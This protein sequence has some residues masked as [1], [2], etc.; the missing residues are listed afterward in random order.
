MSHFSLFHSLFF[1][2]FFCLFVCFIYIKLICD[3]LF[4]FNFFFVFSKLLYI[5]VQNAIYA[6]IVFCFL[7][8]SIFKTINSMLMLPFN[9]Y[10]FLD[11]Y[12]LHSFFRLLPFFFF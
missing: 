4:Y 7:S 5:I 12:I 9:V 1:T 10:V 11:Y 3:G 2:S 8:F 6:T